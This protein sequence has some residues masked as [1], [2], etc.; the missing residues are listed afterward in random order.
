VFLTLGLFNIIINVGLLLLADRFLEKL[1]IQ[2]F[3]TA[4]WAVI[5]FS[6][7]NFIISRLNKLATN[8]H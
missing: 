8:K 5:L 4:F 3:W 2:S 6:L 7:T 1:S